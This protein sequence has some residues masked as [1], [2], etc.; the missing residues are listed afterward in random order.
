[1]HPLSV[2]GHSIHP[3]SLSLFPQVLQSLA[4]RFDPFLAQ[5]D[6]LRA[7]FVAVHDEVLAPSPAPR[8]PAGSKP[9]FATNEAWE[10]NERE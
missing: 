2:R 4:P 5:A 7:L 1:M 3:L 9:A 10:P 6:C 8:Q